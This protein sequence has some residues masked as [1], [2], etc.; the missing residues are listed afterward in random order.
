M[1]MTARHARAPVGI[2][3]MVGAAGE[4]HFRAAHLHSLILYLPA[5][6]LLVEFLHFQVTQ[7]I[8]DFRSGGV[9]GTNL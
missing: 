6:K 1:E 5:Q 2:R 9:V 7:L 4:G 8:L 3:A